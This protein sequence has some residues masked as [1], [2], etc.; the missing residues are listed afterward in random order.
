MSPASAPPKTAS[1]GGMYVVIFDIVDVFD[2][3]ANF[4][5]PTQTTDPW[6]SLGI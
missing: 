4:T 5:A 1:S 6:A 2:S 3:F